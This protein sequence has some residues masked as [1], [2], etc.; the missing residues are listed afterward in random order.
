M[1]PGLALMSL[2]AVMPLIQKQ[3]VARRWLLLT[4]LALLLSLGMGGALLVANWPFTRQ[5]VI[6]ALQESSART[7]TI[8]R[9]YQTYFPPGCVAEGIAFLHRKHKDTPHL[10]TVQKLTIEG[11]YSGLIGSPKRLPRVRVLGMHITVPPRNP[12][13]TSPGMPLTD[14]KSS[15]PI[16]IGTVFA[17][18]VVLDVMSAQPGKVAYNLVIDKLALDG[19]GNNKPISYRAKISNTEPPGEIQSTGRFGPWNAE[20][21]GRTP[22]TG[23]YTFEHADLGVFKD[24]SGILSSSGEF[25]GTLDRL[26]ISGRA[27]VPNFHVTHSGHTT[28]VT[29]Q[30]HASVHAT[31]G[32]TLLENVHSHFNRT[33][34]V[35]NGSVAGRQ[36]EKGKTVSLVV[37]TTNGRIEDLL[38]L[39]I[40]AKRLPMTGSVSLRAKVVVPPDRRAF[41]EKVK[42]E[43]DFGLLSGKFTSGETQGPLNKLSR[44][45]HGKQTQEEKEDPETALS[46]LKGHVSA[47]HGIATLTNVFFSIPGAQAQVGGTYNLVTQE[48][49]LHGVL[50]T[51]GKVY[52]MTQGFKS[53]LLRAMTPFLKHEARATIVPFK[54]TG[55]YPNTT[56][57]LKLFSKK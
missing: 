47:Q 11:S 44:S 57:G 31:D 3:H 4:G 18:A 13:G 50:R 38:H 15:R 29:T 24:I 35:S 27:N 20:D 34:L 14:V 22:I 9:F 42:V 17:D 32:D 39:V 5:S 7:V 46:N 33:I 55:T 53:F 43:A 45:A 48:V 41:L 12:D 54:V 2:A 8:D 36:G 49:N 40:A 1:F 28:P 19:V 6:D 21:P 56:I 37:S 25:S 30:F 51:D 23:S 52:V 10:I 16:V 26:E